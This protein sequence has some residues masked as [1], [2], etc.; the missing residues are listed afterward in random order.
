[1]ARKMI[2]FRQNGNW[3]KTTNFLKKSSRFNI[4]D[5][6]K[7]YGEEGVALLQ[8]NTPVDTGKTANSWYYSI[9]VTKNLASLTFSNSNIVDGV[10]IAIIL[11]YGHVTN[12]GGHVEGVDYINPA[13]KP[14]FEDLASRVWEEVMH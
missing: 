1:M 12:N 11:Q 4:K 14:L 9:S 13:I 2:T 8:R 3:D 6:L 5:I 10:P 7:R